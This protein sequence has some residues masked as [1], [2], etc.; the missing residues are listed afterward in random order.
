MS[1]TAQA[2][3][4][5]AIV[6][7]GDELLYGA[8]VDTNGAWMGQALAE[9]GIPVVERRVVGDSDADIGGALAGVLAKA[10]LVVLSGG[11]GPTHDDRTRE[12]VAA[13]LGLDLEVDPALVTMLER[14]F[15]KFGH[16]SLPSNNL[17]QAHI[18]RGGEAL[19]N[20]RGSAPGLLVPV[21]QDPDKRVALL[22]GVPRE[23]KGIFEEE[24]MPRVERLYA[25][26]MSPVLHHWIHTTGIAESLLAERL[27][28]V[29]PED[30]GGVSLAYL[31]RLTGVDLR[32][33]VTDQVDR[34]VAM[35]AASR[36]EGLIAPVVDGFRYEADSGDLVEAIGRL[37]TDQA[38]TL[39]VAESCTGG[40]IAKRLTD[41]AGVS[42]FFQGGVV[43]YS[44]RL[45]SELLGVD[46]GVL[47]QHGAVSEETALAMAQGARERLGGDAAIAITGIAGPGGGSEEKPVGTVW[48]AASLGARTV[49]KHRRFP[50]N[51]E[52]VR[53]RSAQAAL[54]LLHSMLVGRTP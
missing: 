43:A 30:L 20:P 31:P 35:A 53:V 6:T 17:K 32:L 27:R 14:R 40:A 25:H 24:L 26:R 13:H 15:R 1:G 29:L 49:A 22:P 46:E 9:R 39:V 10:D 44:N 50:G 12:A 36:I 28:E 34:D 3:L 51:R 42:S 45:K 41:V 52:G 16:T 47:E 54:A 18:P 19:A 5:A 11:L 8:T 48:Y 4:R 23:M 7:V 33:T 2:A 21:P 37:L 38:L